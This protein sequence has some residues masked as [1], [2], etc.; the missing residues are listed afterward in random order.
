MDSL[1]QTFHEGELA[2]QRTAGAQER[3]ALAGPRVIRDH[4]PQQHRDFFT[5]LPFLVVGM[6]DA[7]GQPWAS[8]LAGP[9][10][11]VHSPQERELHVDAL[12]GGHDPLAPALREGAAIG[13]LGIQPHTRRRNRLNGWVGAL[14]ASGFQVR[15]GQSFGN[16]PK[17]IQARQAEYSAGHG[18]LA[19]VEQLSA[20]DAQARAAL[21]S[22]DTFFVATAHPGAAG[23]A[24]PAHGVDVSHRGGKPGFVK[25]QGDTLTVPD[26]VGN[27]FFNTLGN[28]LLQ[29]RCGLLFIDFEG[30]GLSWISAEAE[31]V[32]EGAE[33]RSFQ[34]AQR[35]V[36][37]HVHGLR[38]AANALPLR[39]QP[40]PASPEVALTGNW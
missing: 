15:V 17:Y 25:V 20:L 34:G 31:V 5:E 36:R 9:P 26:F 40:G 33:L 8:V 16:C 22:A 37:F 6:V 38:R 24:S 12:P 35:L 39:W 30:Q 29:P 11:F 19:A 7:A 2:L 18:D 32:T 21:A 28:L 14:G 4:M 3:L 27:A 23:S 1:P 13:L 10:G